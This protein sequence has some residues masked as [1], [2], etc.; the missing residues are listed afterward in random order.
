MN[1]LRCILAAVLLQVYPI[2][3]F[4]Q[5][6]ELHEEALEQLSAS[7]EEE[8]EN[9]ELLLQ[10]QW[11]LS[12]PLRINQATE[13][14]LLST[15]LFSA[16]QITSLLLYRQLF[17]A[18]ESKYE[19]QAIPGWDISLL[20]KI[21]PMVATG[22]GREWEKKPAAL[23]LNGQHQLLL[24]TGTTL[25]KAKGFLSDSAG[26]K[27]YAGSAQK[28]Y[29]RYTYQ[30]R[31]QLWYGFTTEKDAGEKW[32]DFKGFHFLLKRNGWLKTI[33]LGDYTLNMGQGLL[34]W[35][36]L[37]FGKT[38]EA[39]AVYRQGKTLNAYRS[40]GEWNFHRG[41][42]V[43]A[44][45]RK[46]QLLLFA[47]RRRRTAS[48]HNDSAL[49][50][51]SF[52]SLS[53]S[54]YHRTAAELAAKNSLTET[55]AG[56]QWM[57]SVPRFRMGITVMGSRFS[58][59]YAPRDALYNM[60]SWRGRSLLN[61]S[62]HYSYTIRQF[63]LFGETAW[64]R[65]GMAGIYSVVVSAGRRFEWSLV[66]RYF[67]P[68][69]Q[70]VYGNA[71]GENSRP[72]NEQGLYTGW[73]WQVLPGWSIQGYA[74]FFRFPW[75]K[76]RVSAPTAG[77]E[78]SQALMY[79]KRHRW[80]GSLRWRSGNKM[81]DIADSTVSFPSAWHRTSLRV[82]LQREWTTVFFSSLRIEKNWLA[83]AH[84][85]TGGWSAFADAQY[86]FSKTG[87]QLAGRLLI[88]HTA[89]YDNRIYAYEKDLL[90]SFSIPAVYGRGW[91]YYFQCQGKGWR[92]HVL[93][94]FRLQWWVRWSNTRL[95]DRAQ[96]GSGNDLVN[97][98]NKTEW[99]AQVLLVW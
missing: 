23:L 82:Q 28:Q 98:K 17:G 32:G 1:E 18:L 63:F 74:D 43:E 30:F 86:R 38:G 35:Q 19:L 15:G 93:R 21:W 73:K 61:A 97:G 33:A 79:T 13:E 9:D 60:Y 96:S 78:W 20:R 3:V 99:R 50:A 48:L 92:F 12:Q 41:I 84:I 11:L 22:S 29:L 27:P 24:R 52:S 54:G 67:Q 68:G 64:T 16:G 44:G 14:E 39:I 49:A 71:F 81:Q 2:P 46:W 95:Y 66:G 62:I 87:L 47:S 31:Q 94:D 58:V 7:Q 88:F 83:R 57:Y 26:N 72:S 77:Y 42:A 5:Q 10:Q 25:Q 90:Y 4:S 40:A 76:Y 70:S 56:A 6:E 91:R 59:L 69:Y 75:L 89:G 37:A 36:G 51:G 65:S 53:A 34:C 45:G 8:I 55:T 80:E 85:T